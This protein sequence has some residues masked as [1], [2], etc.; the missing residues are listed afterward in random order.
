MLL[1]VFRSIFTEF[2]CLK[3]TM[4]EFVAIRVRSVFIIEQRNSLSVYPKRCLTENTESVGRSEFR[5]GVVIW[6]VR[7]IVETIDP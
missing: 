6:G 7:E 3:E 5:T 4:K 2:Q 1:A